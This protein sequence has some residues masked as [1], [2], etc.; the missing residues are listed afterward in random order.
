MLN[1]KHDN[2]RTF[3]AIC[4]EYGSHVRI[5]AMPQD[6]QVAKTLLDA[7][8]RMKLIGRG[9]V[10]LPI[11]DFKS[12]D[13]IKIEKIKA[14]YKTSEDANEE[15]TNNRYWFTPEDAT[16]SYDKDGS[17]SYIESCP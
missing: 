7:D 10:K 2:Y 4:K 3:E 14:T 6:C 5:D 9:K 8:Y 13:Q 16:Y 17:G 1:G 11:K 12:V 15:I